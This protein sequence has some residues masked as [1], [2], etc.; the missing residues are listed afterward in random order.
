MQCKYFLFDGTNPYKNLAIEQDL[1][2]Y[3]KKDMYIA[4]LWQNDNTIV[5]GR[6]QDIYKECKVKDFLESNGNIARRR[7]GGGAVYHDLGNLNYSIISTDLDAEKV[8]YY[9]ILPNVMKNLNIEIKYNNRNDLTFREKKF[10]GNATYVDNNIV[11]QHGTLLVSTNIE[12]M[13]AF[14]TPEESKL[15][16][17]HVKSINSRVINLNEINKEI[18]IDL[19]KKTFI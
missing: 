8:Q 5:I 3:A 17:N 9:N 2:K 13:T 18:T 15:A 14:L 12:K 1:M 7:S 11:C 4:F 16:R 6:N 10:S 19:V